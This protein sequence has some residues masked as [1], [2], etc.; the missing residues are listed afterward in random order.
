M[1]QKYSVHETGPRIEQFLR[2][3]LD[4][5]GFSLTFTIEPGDQSRPDFE[6]PDLMVKFQGPDVELL[7]GN[8]AE[9]LLALELVTQE[10]LRMHSDDHSRVSFDANDY[11]ALRIEELRIS[12]LAAAE[13]VKDSGTYFRFNPMNSRERRVITNSGTITGGTAGAIDMGDGN[14]TLT[15][16]AGSVITGTVDGGAGID[17]IVLGGTGNGTF[18]GAVNFESLAV[19]S[20]NWTLASLP[21]L[22]GGLTIGA[23]GTLNGNAATLVG[24]IANAGTLTFNQPADGSFTGTLT[25]VGQLV[26]AGSGALTI[27]SQTGF[28]G[29]TNVAA[30]KLILAGALPSAVTVASGATLAGVGT[31]ASLTVASG[32]TVAPGNSPGTITVTGNFVQAAG[33]TYLAETTAAGASD[34]IVVGGTATIGTGAQLSVTRDTGA[35]AV[36]TRYT[37]LTAAGGISGAYALVQTPSGGLEFRLVQT[38]TGI[39][40]DVARTGAALAGIALS[41]NQIAVT[42]AVVALGA[43]NAAYAALTMISDD[44][45]TRAGLDSLSGEIHASARTA[46]LLD[47]RAAQQVVRSRLDAVGEGPSLW[48]QAIRRSGNDDGVAS[49]GSSDRDG[50]S[51]VGGVDV[52]VGEAFRAGIAAGYTSTTL[53]VSARSSAARIKTTHAL[54]YVGGR[55]GALSVRGGVGYAWV[56]N[57]VT[58]TVAFAGFGDALTSRGDSSVLSG[59]GEL[60]MALPVMGSV[61]EPFGGIAAYRIHSDPFTETGGPAALAGA[62]RSETFAQ[63]SLGLRVATPIVAGVR[64]RASAAWEHTFGDGR[65]D[66]ALRFTNGAVP[67]TVTGA[68]LSRNAAALALDG[69]WALQDGVTLSAGY[70]GTIGDRGA[71]SNLH[72]GLAVRF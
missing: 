60:G 63:S 31:V 2:Q 16:L 28:T 29:A 14:D 9:L 34:R 35:Y 20:G 65:P 39:F 18:A 19:N 57:R 55:F 7:L 62:A 45:A 59:F 32:G 22:T 47:T 70:A 66:A 42:P 69:D 61:V 51:G 10:M 1:S 30:G 52:G 33:S 49:T 48:I 54:A 26:K 53:D 5:A 68:G 46:A 72:L 37:L 36:G 8:R 24:A 17:A 38:G 25:G 27:G 58:R 40:V 71:D 3:I 4:A 44:A 12:A 11:R 50:W 43:G 15:L 64:A 41:P 13:R 21:A 6:N 56:K 67:F 23:S